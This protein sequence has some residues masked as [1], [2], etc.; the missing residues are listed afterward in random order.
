MLR[1]GSSRRRFLSSRTAKPDPSQSYA[2]YAD[3]KNSLYRLAGNRNTVLA[4]LPGFACVRTGTKSRF[5]AAGTTLYTATANNP[6]IVPGE[7][8]WSETAYTNLLTNAGTAVDLLTQTTAALTV[9]SYTISFYGTG[10]VTL[11]GASTA[12]P[13]VGTGANNRVRLT[14]TPTAAALTVT[15]SGSCKYASLVQSIYAG[16]LIATAG[17][18]ASVGADDLQF[19]LAQAAPFTL[20][21][22]GK[23]DAGVA[24]NSGGNQSFISAQQDATNFSLLY[25][26]AGGPT[27]LVREA[28]TNTAIVAPA[29]TAAI[30]TIARVVGR[31][32]LNNANASY[33][34]G[35]VGVVDTSTNPPTVALVSTSGFG[36]LDGCIRFIGVKAGALTDAQL[37]TESARYVL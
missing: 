29:G 25:M 22:E 33:N 37:I 7:G 26:S 32:Q 3:F 13:L 14:F 17:A 34:G 1:W 12:G 20:Y 30:D 4:S 8:C 21:G 23:P 10:T 5:N 2:L 9:A 31:F 27:A 19:T 35:A 15:V 36:A 24:L 18:A 16:P 28:G 6:L 11:T